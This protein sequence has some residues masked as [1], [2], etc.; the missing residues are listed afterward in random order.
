MSELRLEPW[1][2]DDLWLLERLHGDPAM[3]EHLGGAW[4]SEQIA[5]RHARYVGLVDDRMFKVI[6][7]STGEAV[8]SVGYWTRSWRGEEVYETG[9]FVLP[10]HQG[11]GIAGAATAL[12]LDAAR[13]DGRHRFAHA[14]PNVDNAASNAVCRK[15]GFEL[16]GPL[17]F[18][19]PTG[20]W[21]RCN[22]W[23]LDL[24][25]SSLPS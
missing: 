7:A 5:D 20:S 25:A 13:K 21:M 19:Y 22:D 10:D 18:E 6:D 14:F 4:S 3:M 16:L 2:Q 1:G 17:D 12:A 24:R 8:G 15:L 11:R 23:R 9:W